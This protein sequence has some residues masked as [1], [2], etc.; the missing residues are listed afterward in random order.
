[1]ER[2]SSVRKIATV[3][4]NPVKCKFLYISIEKYFPYVFLLLL[5]VKM[6]PLVFSKQ[7]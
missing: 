4:V 3:N 5:G 1:M 6:E 7:A 2:I